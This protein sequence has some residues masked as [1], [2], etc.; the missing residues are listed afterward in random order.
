MKHHANLR[1]NPRRESGFAIIAV[2][3]LVGL[4]GM[5]SA[6]YLRNVILDAGNSEVGRPA[7]DAREAVHSGLQWG[8]QALRSGTPVTS[9]MV[10]S[11][12]R[13]A[14]V[15][16]TDLPDDRARIASST[17]D[18]D[19]LGATVVTETTRRREAVTES[20]DTLP[21]L[22][23]TTVAS[24][25]ADPTVPKIY[26]SG[27]QRL[28][29][30]DVTGLIILQDYAAL[31]LDNVTVNGAIV[32]AAVLD[33]ANPVGDYD[34]TSAPAVILDGN[35]R[36]EPG[37]FLPGVAMLLPDGVLRDWTSPTA[38][39]IEGDIVAHTIMLDAIDGTCL[40]NIACVAP[41]D[42]SSDVELPGAAR[43]PR[44]WASILD[45][46]GAWDVETMAYVPRVMTSS[47]VSSITS[48][49]IP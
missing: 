14:T 22:D 2:L 10:S 40:G 5:I 15:T 45:M 24:L 25:L 20:P 6:T 27:T 17:I 11:G 42:L 26:F 28:E 37:D 35:L 12:S 44:D 31:Y 46:S 47:D 23:A 48:F 9:T 3:L 43:T 30:T 1:R 29:D 4:I 16:V 7:I 8:R 21:S 18:S 32:S 49:K 36:I 41:L 39:Q 19:G 13:T 33:S 38:I 34:P